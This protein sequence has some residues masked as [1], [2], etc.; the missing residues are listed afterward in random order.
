MKFGDVM[1]DVFMRGKAQQLQLCFIGAQDRPISTHQM[2]RDAAVLEEILEVRRRLVADVL[3][4]GLNRAECGSSL[5]VARQSL[6]LAH[7]DLLE[8]LRF[9]QRGQG[10]YHSRCANPRN[11]KAGIPRSAKPRISAR[12]A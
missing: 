4:V 11:G 12:L 6:D 2:K 7:R 5:A 1:A 10:F 3:E 9:P 8:V